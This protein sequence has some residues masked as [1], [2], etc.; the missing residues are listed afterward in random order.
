[1][2]IVHTS[3]CTWLFVSVW[4][5]CVRVFFFFYTP[6]EGSKDKKPEIK[7]CFNFSFF[8]FFTNDP[9]AHGLCGMLTG[10]ACTFIPKSITAVI[11]ECMQEHILAFEK[12]VPLATVLSLP[13]SPPSS[14]DQN[15]LWTTNSYI[16]DRHSSSDQIHALQPSPCWAVDICKIFPGTK[17][18]MHEKSLSQGLHSTTFY[19]NKELCFCGPTENPVLFAYWEA[20]CQAQP[21][22][23]L[24]WLAGKQYCQHSMFFV[25]AFITCM[26][27]A[28]SC[29]F[30][31]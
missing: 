14:W 11:I 29:T 6:H 21:V 28:T 16:Y 5:K 17:L 22:K 19:L 26:F 15:E 31:S 2:K 4:H 23:S 24:R 7:W 13:V 27:Y 10:T 12:N 1:M 9:F 20:G 25:F 3:A 30:L 18:S 8:S